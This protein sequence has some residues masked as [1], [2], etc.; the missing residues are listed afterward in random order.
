MSI[1]KTQT[2][3]QFTSNKTSIFEST[4]NRTTL[5]NKSDI[6]VI[7]AG[8][9]GLTFAIKMAEKRPDVSITVLTKTHEG[10]SNTRYA[11]GGVAAVWNHQQDNFKKHIACGIF[12]A[13]LM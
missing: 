2:T 7:G 12:L 4:V 6:L 11:Q 8:V 13:M 1:I 9:A 10:E 5:K 3:F